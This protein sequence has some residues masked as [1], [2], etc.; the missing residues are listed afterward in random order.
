[1]Y[2]LGDVPP[3][4]CVVKLLREARPDE[5]TVSGPAGSRVDRS[6][7]IY[8][9]GTTEAEFNELEYMVPAKS[10]R[11]A[12]DLIRDLQLHRFTEEISPLQIRWQKADQAYLSPQYERDSVSVSVSGVIG[13]NYE[14]FLRAVDHELQAFDARPHWGKLHFLTP[15]R[16]R[17]LYPCFDDFQ[18]VRRQFDPAGLFLND[19][20]RELFAD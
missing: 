6:H 11:D 7:L 15:E 9:D 14:P 13:K 18:S 17:A 19:H 10:A 12:V 20:L 4:H 3:D 2:D 8:P 1:M 16:V 5:P